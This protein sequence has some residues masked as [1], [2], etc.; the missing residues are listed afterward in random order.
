MTLSRCCPLVVGI[1][2]LFP[3]CAAAASKP[4]AACPL[5]QSSEID[6]AVGAKPGEPNE[7]DMVIP[8]G[9]AQ[10]ETM[11]GCMVTVSVIRAPAGTQR[12]AGLAKLR[13]ATAA[14]EAQGWT[15][16][17]KVIGGTKCGTLVPP[18]QQ[19]ESMPVVVGCMG[20]AKGLALSV[21][22]MIA[23]TRVPPEKV[24]ALF[25]AAVSRLP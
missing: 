25:D 24:K 20:E 15:R 11:T 19:S 14:L 21:S 17:E 8:K 10:G 7:T 1:V 9:P 22:S 4:P 3:G 18:K 2:V 16:E 5:L 6:A 12:D 13:E 23:R